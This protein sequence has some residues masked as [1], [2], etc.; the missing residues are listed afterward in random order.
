ME[1]L[2]AARH[3]I[4][5]QLPLFL[6]LRR[7]R[8]TGLQALLDV[9]HLTRPAFSLLRAVEG[10]TRRGQSLTLRQMQ[11][12]LFNPYATRFDI[13]EQLPFLVER[14]YLQQ[15]DGGYLVTDAGCRLV[16]QIEIAARTYMGTL[17]VPAS[18][19]LSELAVDLVDLVHRG[20]QSPE[21]LIKA[22]QERTQR[23]L[24]VEGAPE[25][26]QIE[27]AILGLW[28]ARDD[29]HMAAWRAYRFSGSVFD[30]LTRIW[31]KEAQTLPGLISLLEESQQSTD[32]QQGILELSKLGYVSAAEDHFELT[33][34]GQRVRD[35]I[36]GET[37]RIF[38]ASWE[39]IA[40]D[41]VIWLSEQIS[42]LCVYL[43]GLVSSDD[44]G[45]D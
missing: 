7:R 28:E 29:A 8:W 43:R 39:Q 18:V 1:T 27:W 14:G 17:Q 44:V 33:A 36:E 13:F 42:D 26:V 24:S 35:A 4:V 41:K 37:D 12:H 21:P 15:L 19:A 22:H 11:E 10:E 25:L 16:D 40:D 34:Q 45:G 5:E 23:R 32:I 30:I 3:M 31:S 6:Q 20:W 9:S 38:F 2:T